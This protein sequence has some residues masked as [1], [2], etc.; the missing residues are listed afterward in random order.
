VWYTERYTATAI[1]LSRHRHRYTEPPPPS[2]PPRSR[3]RHCLAE[4]GRNAPESNWCWNQGPDCACRP[5]AARGPDCACRPAAARGPDCA[6]RPA[7]ARGPDCACLPA[8]ARGP[9]CACRTGPGRA[10]HRGGLDCSRCQPLHARWVATA[11]AGG[12]AWR[13]AAGAH[14]SFMSVYIDI[15]FYFLYLCL[16]VE[17]KVLVS[18]FDSSQGPRVIDT[19]L[20]SVF[21][22]ANTLPES[23][24]QDIV[25]HRSPQ[26]CAFISRKRCAQARRRLRLLGHWH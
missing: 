1:V 14:N 9:D 26:M 11:L 12:G 25:K 23:P 8:A 16:Y 13:W 10:C 24:I 4:S 22:R 7:A 17:I 15:L 5:A 6:C 21:D 2:P 20:S 18:K 19:S 3:H